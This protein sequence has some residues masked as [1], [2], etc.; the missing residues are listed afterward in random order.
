MPV[1]ALILFWYGGKVFHRLFGV[2]V[3]QVDMPV[4]PAVVQACALIAV[5]EGQAR[6]GGCVLLLLQLAK[7]SPILDKLL[8]GCHVWQPQDPS[9]DGQRAS[10]VAVRGTCL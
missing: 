6:C 8:W 9:C 2:L 10:L 3:A 1:H 4:A 5:P 7:G